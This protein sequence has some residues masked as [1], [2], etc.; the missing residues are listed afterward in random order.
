MPDFGK[1]LLSFLFSQFS[2]GFKLSASL[3]EYF[4]VSAVQLVG[5]CR[6]ANSAVQPDRVVVLNVL[7]YY[8]SGVVKERPI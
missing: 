5:W 4:L 2:G 7:F 3:F 8:L 1:G 6:V